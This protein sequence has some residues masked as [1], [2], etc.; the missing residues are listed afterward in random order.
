MLD[1]PAKPNSKAGSSAAAALAAVTPAGIAPGVPPDVMTLIEAVRRQ[2]RDTRL[3]VSV[4]EA[5]HLIGVGR[6]KFYQL[7]TAGEI[8]LVKIG[9]A[10]RVTVAS[11]ESYV[12]RLRAQVRGKVA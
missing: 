5:M 7:V 3:L 8:E 1:D 4:T 10:S 9:T 6:T 2:C 11:L 12:E